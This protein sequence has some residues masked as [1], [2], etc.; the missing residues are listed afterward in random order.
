MNLRDILLSHSNK[1]ALLD[2]NGNSLNYKELVVNA[3]TACV[4]IKQSRSLVFIE[5]DS[6][7]DVIYVY[8]GCLLLGHVPLMLDAELS[9]NLKNSLIKIYQPNYIFAKAQFSEYSQNNHN[10]NDALALLL[11]TSGST[12]S[13]KLVKLT[14]NNVIENAKSIATY[15]SLTPSDRAI[16][17]LPL[18]YSYGLSV[19]NSHLY[20]GASVVVTNDTLF[21]KEFWT[22]VNELGVT[23]LAGVP[24]TYEMYKRLRIQNMPLTNI[25]YLTQAGGKMSST[26][27]EEFFLLCESRGWDF[28]IMYGQTEATARMSYLSPDKLPSKI[29]SIGRAIPGGQFVISK[30]L[31]ND[32]VGEIIYHGRNVMLGYATSLADLSKGDELNGILH[33]GDLGYIDQDGDLYIT[34]RNSRFIKIFGLRFNLDQVE[35]AIK[36]QGYVV[37]VGGVDDHLKVVTTCEVDVKSIKKFVIDTFKLNHRAITVEYVH[38]IITKSSGKVDYQAIFGEL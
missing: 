15:L 31:D 8:L 6:S 34:G 11:S 25:R 4:S 26:T 13:P 32:S 10:L 17:N 12:G 33:T 16:T 3:E 35:N 22:A 37:V 21:S 23:S 18:N 5:A 20:S 36:A 2:L 38:E 1:T 28:Y 30:H 29:D 14:I 27:I 9:E 19:L 24:Y 7:F